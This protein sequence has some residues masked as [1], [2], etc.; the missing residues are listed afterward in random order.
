MENAPA[1][2]GHFQCTMKRKYF[3]FLAGFL[4]LLNVFVWK[5]VF[6]LAGS[7]SL[8]V[9]FLD[10]GQGDAVFIKTPEEHQILIDGGPDSSALAGLSSFIP[11]WD[12]TIDVVILTH[13][14]KDHM[15][16]LIDI[17]Q[18]YKADYILW[19]GVKRTTPEYN[20]WLDVLSKQKSAGAKIII[21]EP[22]LRIKAGNVLIN[23]LYPLE[24]LESKQLKDSANDTSIVSY[25]IFGRNSF[26][27]TGDIG[28][29]VE[30]DI[31]NSNL[32]GS[33]DVLKVSHHGSKYSTSELFLKGV[34]PKIAVISASKTN[35]YGHPTP[36]VLQRLEKF[37]I[38][39]K[40][41]DQ[42]GD[43]KIL[44]DGNNI[45]IKK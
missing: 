37:G 25:L 34:K 35:P 13:P 8:L 15:Q 19:T 24:N 36:E 6:V 28:A 20:A 4:L 21:S 17:L 44:S 30:K 23:T 11:S 33:L 14:E 12:R 3:A 40:R 42:D 45:S 27:F 38:Q 2:R 26:L 43:V 22:G 5:D 41:T 39:I 16:G 18:R 31:I 7:H 9:N 29:S 10:V 1:T 32:V